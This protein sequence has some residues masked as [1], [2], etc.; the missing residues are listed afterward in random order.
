MKMNFDA[1]IFDLGGVILNIDYNKT[2]NAFK[3]LGVQNFDSLYTQAQQNDLFD[4]LEVGS[5]TENDFY[6][7]IKNLAATKLSNQQIQFAWN[8]ML[9][10]LPLARIQFLR[11]LSKNTPIYLLSNT[12]SIHLSAFKSIIKN[13]HG[14]HDLLESIF[15][16]TFY[17][18]QIG[19][20]KPN[21]E[22]FNLIIAKHQLNPSTTLFI[23]DSI[24][25]IEGAKKVGLQAHHLVNQ[26]ITSLFT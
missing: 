10:D 15:I 18:H 26:D 16:E 9:L 1:I 17:S 19:F 14:D 7:E 3:N 12:N 24:Q 4:K 2:I 13:Q 25:H 8:A 23:D 22:A 6:S 11:N 5:I 20:R 21:A